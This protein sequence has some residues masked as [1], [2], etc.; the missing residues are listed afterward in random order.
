MSAGVLT[1]EGDW[2][3]LDS[4]ARRRAYEKVG[5]NLGRLA[6]T[7]AQLGNM[8]LCLFMDLTKEDSV[9]LVT[10]AQPMQE[11][12]GTVVSQEQKDSWK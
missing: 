7:V 4:V 10:M 8:N 12:S 11:D 1:M 6:V 5:V 2:T 9:F 3:N